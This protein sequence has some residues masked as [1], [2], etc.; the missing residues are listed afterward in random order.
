MR[1]GKFTSSAIHL[2]MKEGRQAGTFG[3][4]ALKYIKEKNRELLLGRELQKERSS[5]PTSWGNLVESRVYNLLSTEYTLCSSVRYTHSDIK[6]WSGAPDMIT[7]T[8]VCDI[9]CPFSLDVFCDKA[10]LIMANDVEGLK[11]QF[12]ENY[13]QLI[14][15]SILTEKNVC[16]LIIYMPYIR[17]I[18]EIKESLS[19]YER[20]LNEVAWLNWANDRELPYLIEGNYY[21]NLYILT[22]EASEEDKE[23]LTQRVKQAIEL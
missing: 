3:A 9:K 15:N 5:R 6:R 18:L 12:P 2:L 11:K 17:E 21:K 1:G 8:K 10:D 4:P 13:W 19:M 20:D 16:E 23:Y 7:D 22:W 14:S